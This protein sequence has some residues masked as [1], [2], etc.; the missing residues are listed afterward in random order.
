[1]GNTTS[2]LVWL[3][4]LLQD[5]N[6]TLDDTIVLYCDNE[7]DLHIDKNSIY[8]ERTKHIERDCHVVRERLSSSF[9]K[10]LHVNIQHQLAYLLTNP[11]TALQ[12]NHLLSK[13]GIHHIYSPS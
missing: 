7:V 1:M 2:E 9:L 12:F 13:M 5:L 11:L 10:T 8:H 6:I 4:S 3:S